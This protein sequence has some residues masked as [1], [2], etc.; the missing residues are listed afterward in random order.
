MSQSIMSNYPAGFAN[1][2]TVRG[3]P[4][5]QTHPGRAFW[6]SNNATGLLVGQRGGSDQNR[7]TFDSPFATLAGAIAAVSA[8]TG[9][10]RG[11]IIFIKPGHAETISAAGGI[12]LN[13]AGIAIVGLGSGSNRPKFT[14][15]TANTATIAVSA[16]NISIQNCQ[17]VANF[18]S[19]A[20]CFALTTAKN[21]TVQNCTF[22]DTSSVLNFLNIVKSTGIANTV[23]GLS[24]T[25][26]AWNG[27]GTTS[28]N[29]FILTANDIDSAVI[30]RNVVKLAR[31]ATAAILMTVTAG[32][33]TNLVSVGNVCI[34]QQVADTGGAFINVG[35]TTSTG[36]VALNYLGDLSTTDLFM[37]TSVGVTF[38][39]NKKTGV[40]SA[41]GYLLPA[42]D[43]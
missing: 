19:I 22:A 33:L 37:T 17:F 27:L 5:V 16:D 2:V 39:D 12:A 8:F 26:C 14:L 11:D 40:I 42:A 6:V 31:T 13:V 3:V 30:S 32:V 21:F 34:S 15:N 23:D 41:S 25:D 10:N 1:G 9:S 7:G 38:F 35:G 28:V 4:L 43:S 36:V 24:V 18:L 20:T 29:S